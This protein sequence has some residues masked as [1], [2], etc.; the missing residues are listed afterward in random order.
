V[1]GEREGRGRDLLAR[2]V[3]EVVGTID[4]H[5]TLQPLSV[6]AKQ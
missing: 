2:V 1:L 6:Y 4:R 5:R 3:G